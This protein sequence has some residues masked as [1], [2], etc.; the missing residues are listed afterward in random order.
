[1]TSI[2]SA[3]LDP[4]QPLTVGSI[5]GSADLHD[6]DPNY[7]A[8]ACDLIE[9]R[10]DLLDE[11]SIQS[12]AWKKFSSM[13]ILFTARRASEGGEGDHDATARSTMLQQALPDASLIDLELASRHDM[14]G[15]LEHVTA[16]HIPW[17]ASVHDFS[18]VPSRAQLE[19]ARDEARA[20]GAAAFKAA[21][22][23]TW[24]TDPIPDLAGFLQ[25]ADGYP[26]ALM[27]MGP[28]GPSSRILFA[29]LGSV[30]NYGYLG[31][32]P[33]A[34]GQWSAA[35]LHQAIQSCQVHPAISKS[36]H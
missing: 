11:A 34:P 27:G 15:L 32:T 14:S 28:L 18:G 16:A 21:V 5:G 2:A 19:A 3:S 1:M 9:I 31:Q 36:T 30:L 13:P 24:A 6:L 33:T 4:S 25:A 12:A 22:T 23:L 17:V 8:S 29:Q 35:Q 26:T 7:V 20:A 10:L